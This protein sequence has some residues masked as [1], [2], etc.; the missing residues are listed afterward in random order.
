[1][2][3]TASDALL[4]IADQANVIRQLG[5]A[6]AAKQVRIAALE[7]EV[8][9]LAPKPLPEEVERDLPDGELTGTMS[10]DGQTEG[11]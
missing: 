8:T 1:M 5:D 7:A 3:L 11:A 10:A 2:P 4:T 6:L 9:R